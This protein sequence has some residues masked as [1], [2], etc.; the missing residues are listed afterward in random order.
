MKI[1]GKVTLK[2]IET[3]REKIEKNH[4]YE[5]SPSLNRKKAVNFT[6][7]FLVLEIFSIFL[8]CPLQQ[9]FYRRQIICKNDQA[10]NSEYPS[11]K[12]RDQPAYE[13]NNNQNKTNGKSD[14]VPYHSTNDNNV[15]I[16]C[17]I[18]DCRILL[19]QMFL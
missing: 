2:N 9:F 6:L 5:E 11:L 14:S 17:I 16:K 18:K 19:R 4:N 12:D 13:S 8:L 10:G 15:V 3:K 1:V 7:R